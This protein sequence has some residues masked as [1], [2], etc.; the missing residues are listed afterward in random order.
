MKDRMD[1]KVVLIV[2]NSTLAYQHL[3]EVKKYL[4]FSVKCITGYSKDKVKSF[5]AFVNRYE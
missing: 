2:N 3:V 1:A 4:D 5:A